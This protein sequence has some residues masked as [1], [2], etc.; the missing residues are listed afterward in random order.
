[1][2][3]NQEYFTAFPILKTNRLTLRKIEEQDAHEIFEMRANTRTNEFILRPNME[4]LES[5]K[6]L[7]QKVDEGYKNKQNLA[8]AGLLREQKK[9]IGTC[10]FSTIDHRNLRAEIGGELFVNYWG[11]HIALEAVTAI[12]EFGF[13]T[14]NLHNIEAKLNP[15]NRGSIYLLE[16]LGF[17][18]EAHFKDFGYYEDRFHDLLVYSKINPN[19][20]KEKTV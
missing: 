7:V 13:N 14:L 18:K 19:H 10:G 16:Y 12:I 20:K 11:K 1:M 17:E 9:I 8:W 3:L 5:A 4:K 6:E 15:G 2:Q